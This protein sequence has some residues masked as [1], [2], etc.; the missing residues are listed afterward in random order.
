M[1]P[2][3]VPS[4]PPERSTAGFEP[5]RRFLEPASAPMATAPSQGAQLAPIRLMERSFIEGNVLEYP[6]FRLSNKELK[7]LNGR[8]KHG[9]PIP[10]PK[11]YVQEY[12]FQLRE[13]GGAVRDAKVVLKA[14]VHEGFPGM[15]AKQI[16]FAVIQK[17]QESDFVSQR[18]PITRPEICRRLH[19]TSYGGHQFNLIDQALRALS[20]YR[21]EF[22]DSWHDGAKRS[23]HPG[24]RLE[25]LV[26]GFRFRSEG[27]QCGPQP[28]LDEEF[29]E[30]GDVAAQTG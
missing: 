20:S 18:V 17:S 12:A 6:L 7:P 22:L 25:R 4:A 11:D 10:D 30:L 24:T 1:I 28:E 13:Q 23:H 27:D 8:G 26:K 16:L 5:I 9:E 19:M 14:D 15:F 2:A 21:I 29:V 3:A